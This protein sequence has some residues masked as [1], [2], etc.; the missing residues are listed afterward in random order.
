MGAGRA[1][2]ANGRAAA[3]EAGLGARP[4]GRRGGRS[5]GR[6]ACGGA[7]GSRGTAGPG[8]AD[9]GRHWPSMLSR[10]G[11]PSGAGRARERER[12]ASE[13]LGSRQRRQ[14]TRLAAGRIERAVR[15]HLGE[16]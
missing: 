6:C 11:V 12:G 1:R 14:G 10:R 5:H 4:G 16:R 2:G 13:E 9:R 7:E 3:L 8:W 15:A